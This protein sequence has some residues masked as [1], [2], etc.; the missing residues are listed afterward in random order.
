VGN[1]TS[2]KR[3]ELACAEFIKVIEDIS[4]THPHG[5][6]HIKT[7]L[8]HT[9]MAL[10]ISSMIG[11]QPMTL[12]VTYKSKFPYPHFICNIY[13]AEIYV[14]PI[15]SSTCANILSYSVIFCL[16]TCSNYLFLD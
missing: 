9:P 15:V 3:Q 11:K 1:C 10:N 7:S 8:R 5:I 13:W 6:E 14:S 4:K 16:E 2:G 12:S